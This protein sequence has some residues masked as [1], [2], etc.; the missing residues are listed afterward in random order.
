MVSVFFND[1]ANPT[2]ILLCFILMCRL[3]LFKLTTQGPKLKTRLPS[4]RCNSLTHK[5]PL[6][7]HSASSSP[8]KKRDTSTLGGNAS[9]SQTEYF[10]CVSNLS[11]CYDR[12]NDCENSSI[13]NGGTPPHSSTTV[14]EKTDHR[15]VV[16]KSMV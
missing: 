11:S 15:I 4:T 16:R 1:T 12:E 5:S 7:S 6:K 2:W 13:V 10:T 8:S 14:N 3:K 9:S